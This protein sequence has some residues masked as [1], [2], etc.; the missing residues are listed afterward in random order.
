MAEGKGPGI[1]ESFGLRPEALELIRGVF[2][3]HPEVQRVEVFGSRAMGRFEDHSDVDLALWGD[4]DLGRIGRI[5]RE[6]DELPLPYTFDIKA[7]PQPRRLVRMIPARHLIRGY[8]GAL[9]MRNRA[10]TYVIIM[11]SNPVARARKTTM[12]RMKVGSMS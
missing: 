4:L 3:R 5:A 2:R 12:I 9:G 1:E 10:T 11:G 7:V 6:L 8:Q